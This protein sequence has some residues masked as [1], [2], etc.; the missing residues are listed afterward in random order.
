M[1]KSAIGL[2]CVSL[3]IFPNKAF[4]QV[5]QEQELDVPYVPSPYEVVAEMLRIAEVGKKDILYDLGCGD[6][7]IVIMAAQQFGTRGIG[8]DINPERIE[9]SKQNAAQAGVEKLVQFLE[10]DLFQADIHRATVV[11]LYL[12]PSVNL[13]LRPKL[14]RELRPGTRIVSHDFSMSE[15][16]PDKSSLVA[17]DDETHNIYFWVV[18]ANV[19]GTWEWAMPS[20]R[21][22]T[23]YKLQMNQIFQSVK[24]T[25]T[26]GKSRME[27]MQAKL[28]GD[29][30]QFAI[31]QK[32]G[33]QTEELLFEGR[34]NGN[35]IEGSVES[36]VRPK[37]TRKIWKAR[38]AAST[39]KALDIS[40]E[41]EDNI[42][43]PI[44]HENK[45]PKPL[46]ASAH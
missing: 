3:F 22:E 30:L 19:T 15:W 16:E 9:E 17:V 29:K 41:K 44:K 11:S 24:G 43:Y 27:I 36:Q 20:A 4:H 2:L 42:F 39:V 8:V 33:G 10:K 32:V 13:R 14:L 37:S 5:Y 45:T 34:I 28:N 31:E 38:R 6:G 21:K 23:P 1:K 46:R 35:L 18:P 40:N 7:R 12:L 25:V 26:A